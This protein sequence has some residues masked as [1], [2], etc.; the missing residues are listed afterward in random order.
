M[1]VP[2]YDGDDVPAQQNSSPRRWSF[3]IMTVDLFAADGKEFV[4]GMSAD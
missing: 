3:D 1:S 4:R 2:L